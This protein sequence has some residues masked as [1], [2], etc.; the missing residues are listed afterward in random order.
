MARSLK[1]FL[2]GEPLHSD[3]A[4]DE[5]LSNPIALA[6]FSSDALSSVAYATEEIMLVLLAAGALALAASVPITL[7]ICAL[8]VIVAVSYR[9]TIKAYP[10]GGGAYLVAREN[11]G[12]LPGLVAGGSLLVGYVL[13][14]AVSVAAGTA[15]VTSALPALGPYRVWIAVALVIGLAFANLRGLR[16]AGAVFAGPTYLF[17]AAIALLIVVGLVRYLTGGITPSVHEVAATAQDLTLFLLLRAFS[18]GCAAMTGVEAIA[19]GVQAFRKPAARNATT[20]LVWMAAILIFLFAGITLLA[21]LLGVAPMEGGE[22]VLSQIARGVFGGGALYYI[23]QAATASILVLAAN[24]SYAGFPRLSSFMAADGFMPGL[25]RDKGQRLVHSNGVLLLTGAAVALLI[26]SGSDTHRLIPLYAIGVFSSFTL[27]QGG[28]VVHWFR[29]REPGW[30]A[31][32]AVNA[33]GAVV[34]GIVTLVIAVT[35]FTAGAWIVL[36]VM[37]VLV[38]YFMWVRSEYRKV[39]KRLGLVLETDDA[40]EWRTD[41]PP[42]RVIVLVGTIDRRIVPALRYARSIGTGGVEGLFIDSTGEQAGPMRE[43]WDACDFGLPLVVVESPFRQIVDPI[44][45]YIRSIPREAD[46]M[47]TVCLPQ[48]V[49]QEVTDY[50]GVYVYRAGLRYRIK[51]ALLSEPNVVVTDVPYSL[52]RERPPA[53]IEPP[54]S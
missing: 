20:T 13:T 12:T 4:D 11:L 3:R 5:R 28:M 10:S 46:E 36:V 22:T 51:R 38:G 29:K 41:T 43:R 42:N 47:I 18:S 37:P 39:E 54:A 32:M 7:A 40:A 35:K 24:T 26:A 45:R 9:Q 33:V 48:F 34:T 2:L 23:V 21:R 17:I 52:R 30:R 14:V 1:R 44:R 6:I 27:S 19:N 49:P 50:S 25:L 53:E 16:E 31:G 8:V 15:A